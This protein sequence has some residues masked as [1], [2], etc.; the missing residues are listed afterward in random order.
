MPTWFIT[1][2]ST[3]LGRHLAQATLT[4]GFN[5]VVTARDPARVQDIVQGYPETAL[6]L[7]LDVT[8]PAQVAQALLEAEH[9]FGGIDV[10][11]NNA[12]YGYR[13]AIEEADMEEVRKMFE[14]NYFGTVAMTKAVLPGMRARRAGTIVNVSSLSGRRSRAGSGNYSATKFAVEGMSDALSQE[15]GPLGI[16]VILVEPGAFRTDFAGRSLQ[17]APTRIADYDQT[18]GLRRK[19]NDGAAGRQPG[20]P[21]KGAEAIIRIVETSNPPL[22]LLLGRDAIATTVAELEAQRAE[23][24]GWKDLSASTD[25]APGG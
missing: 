17:Q 2:C 14:A 3:G 4:R 15:V 8:D 1:G 11:V 20:D 5:V 25:F 18:A 21:A 10:L 12:G 16:R 23:L 22:R 19:G 24:E 7:A 9:R 6:C 13:G